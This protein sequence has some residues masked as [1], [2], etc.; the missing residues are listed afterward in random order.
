MTAK[1]K[2]PA[3]MVCGEYHGFHGVSHFWFRAKP[4]AGK[5]NCYVV[6]ALVALNVNDSCCGCSGCTCGERLFEKDMDTDT[7][8]VVLPDI[9]QNGDIIKGRYPNSY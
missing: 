1:K 2:N 3:R 4:V 6:R 5:P 9:F 8:K 7:W